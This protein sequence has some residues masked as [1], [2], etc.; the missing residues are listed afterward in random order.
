M[1]FSM[2]GAFVP[3]FLKDKATCCRCGKCSQ[4]SK[5]DGGAGCLMLLLCLQMK[6]GGRERTNAKEYLAGLTENEWKV[7]AEGANMVAEVKEKRTAD[8][9]PPSRRIC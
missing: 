2:V 7:F 1:A 5:A 9:V 6:T 4:S 3:V 8:G